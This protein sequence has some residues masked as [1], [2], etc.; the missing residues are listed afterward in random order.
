MSL[1]L[2]AA[3]SAL[4]LAALAAFVPASADA[5]KHVQVVQTFE[6]ARDNGT[7]LVQVRFSNTLVGTFIVDTG[8]IESVIT[9][10]FARKAKFKL[11][12]DENFLAIGLHHVRFVQPP[13]IKLAN[14]AVL[15]PTFRVVS[16]DF[17]PE[18]DGRPIDGI[19]GGNFLSQFALR[20]D[21]PA[22]E[23]DWIMPEN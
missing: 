7:P 16:Q 14:L 9:E 17:L 3:C 21:Y 13:E 11:V 4:L 19:L 8:E 5:P 18:F 22:H 6:P 10:P 1:L 20:I 15:K 2:R 23:I 12:E